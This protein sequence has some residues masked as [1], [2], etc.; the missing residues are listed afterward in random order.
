M[1]NLKPLYSRKIIN[2]KAKDKLEKI[3]FS[4]I[5]YKRLLFLIPK[6]LSKENFQSPIG[7]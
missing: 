7:K 2:K 3:F 5:T 1:Y 4:I 6:E